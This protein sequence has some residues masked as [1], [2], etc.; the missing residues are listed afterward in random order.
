MDQTTK[1]DQRIDRL[2]N[3]SGVP[4][5]LVDA[6]VYV[7]DTMEIAWMIAVEVLGEKATADSVVAIYDRIDRERRCLVGGGEAAL[8]VAAQTFYH[9]L[10]KAARQR[11]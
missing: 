3:T 6:A 4:N 5:R 10:R 9:A 8:D 2:G 11:L 7:N 1:F